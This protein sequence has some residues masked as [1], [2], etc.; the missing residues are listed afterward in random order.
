MTATGLARGLRSSGAIAAVGVGFLLV[1]SAASA[2]PIRECGNYGDTG[3]GRV[4]WTFGE[5]YGA[6]IFNLTSRRVSCRT[7]RRVARYSYPTDRYVRRWSWRGYR[8]RILSSAH[9]Y[10]D[11]RCTKIG[12]RVVRWQSGS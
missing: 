7:A 5:V 11:Q 6:G 8:C 2:A 9:E 3:S 4:G 1:P 12:G 10:S